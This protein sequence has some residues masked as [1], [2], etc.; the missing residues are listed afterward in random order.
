MIIIT[1]AIPWEVG[2]MFGTER[3]PNRPLTAKLKDCALPVFIVSVLPESW[4]AAQLFYTGPPTFKRNLCAEAK[5]QGLRLN[6]SGLW[7]LK[8]RI[9]GRSEKQIFEAL[10]MPWIRPRERGSI[11]SRKRKEYLDEQQFARGAKKGLSRH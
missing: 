8:E 9:A 4:G 7:H 1:T 2:Q 11:I 10:D 3:S 6:V 5:F